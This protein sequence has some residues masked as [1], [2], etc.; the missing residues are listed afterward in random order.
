MMTSGRKVWVERPAE[1]PVTAGACE[2]L[3]TK[4]F[5]LFERLRDLPKMAFVVTS[6][7]RGEVRVAGSKIACGRVRLKLDPEV[8]RRHRA[9]PGVDP[10][11]YFYG[12]PPRPLA[13]LRMA[14][15][16]PWSAELWVE[17]ETGLVWRANWSSYN[18]DGVPL[19]QRID[20]QEIVTG[21]GVPRQELD[22][23][24]E[25]GMSMAAEFFSHLLPR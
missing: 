11:N 15:Q 25:P 7:G 6:T 14:T 9:P 3:E 5:M 2:A 4:R 24:P 21:S 10:R 18:E 20:Y 19:N 1:D 16:W 13:T 8:A 22:F 23:T 12:Q 17:P